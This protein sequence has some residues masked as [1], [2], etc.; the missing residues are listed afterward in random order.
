MRRAGRHSPFFGATRLPVHLA[1][2]SPDG[3]RVATAAQPRGPYSDLTTRVWDAVSGEKLAIL[4]GHT[5]WLTSLVFS[6]DGTRILTAS[7]D[8]PARVWDAASGATIATLKS[9]SGTEELSRFQSGWH[10][11]THG[12][13]RRGRGVGC[14]ERSSTCHSQGPP[15]GGA[16][17][18]FQSG[19]QAGGNCFQ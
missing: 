14:D 8:S 9:P 10:A 3:M 18:G 1:V 12:R 15:S 7:G 16:W 17:G 13:R 5:S 6:P 11:G 4:K 19:R 2:F